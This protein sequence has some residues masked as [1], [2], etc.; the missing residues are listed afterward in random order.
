MAEEGKGKDRTGTVLAVGGGAA[1]IGLA[2][3]LTMK[4][5]QLN[6]SLSWERIGNEETIWAGVGLAKAKSWYHLEQFGSLEWVTYKEVNQGHD[7]DW[8][9]YSVDIKSALDKDQVPDGFYDAFVFLHTGYGELD[10]N[11]LGQPTDN[12][13]WLFPWPWGM[14]WQTYLWIK[15]DLNPGGSYILGQW[16]ENALEVRTGILQEVGT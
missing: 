11:P 3:W 8:K 5:T 6:V 10:M 2:L 13:D 16:Y 1:L 12:W 14:M 15:R 4:R 7:T 9:Q